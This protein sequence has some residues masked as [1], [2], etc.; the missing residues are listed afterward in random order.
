MGLGYD[1]SYKSHCILAASNTT[2]TFIS[3]HFL[4]SCNLCSRNICNVCI[5]IYFLII[6]SN[7]K[8][9]TNLISSHVS[10]WRSI[11]WLC[12]IDGI[13][14]ISI[15][16]SFALDPF[17]YNLLPW[18]LKLLVVCGSVANIQNRNE[19]ARTLEHYHSI[20]STLP[21]SYNF[22]AIV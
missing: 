9:L 13:R 6:S 22:S 5:E 21:P 10:A 11:A 3:I 7:T 8:A 19:N 14:E 18:Q 1:S 2:F 12:H 4:H 20:K 16:K 15:K 17:C